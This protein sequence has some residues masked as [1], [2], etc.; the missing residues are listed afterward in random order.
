MQIP[1]SAIESILKSQ[2]EW[3]KKREVKS[4]EEYI[5]ERYTASHCYVHDRAAFKGGGGWGSIC[6]H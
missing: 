3:E 5:Y 4:R 1:A 6:P 2:A